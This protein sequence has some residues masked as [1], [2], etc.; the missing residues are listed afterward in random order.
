[1]FRSILVLNFNLCEKKSFRGM[2]GLQFLYW[3]FSLDLAGF[4]L[5]RLR[6]LRNFTENLEFQLSLIWLKFESVS[7]QILPLNS[8]IFQNQSCWILNSLKL[9]LKVQGLI[10]SRNRVLTL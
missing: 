7:L 8:K 10:L 6:T 4:W 9:S 3:D 2:L 5:K 1:M